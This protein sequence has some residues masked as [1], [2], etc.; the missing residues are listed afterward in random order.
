MTD[1]PEQGD[2]RARGE[3]SREGLSEDDERHPIKR[4]TVD[5]NLTPPAGDANQPTSPEFTDG[6][7]PGGSEVPNAPVPSGDPQRESDRTDVQ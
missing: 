4:S 6:L 1:A 2:D 3:T 5:P 7:G